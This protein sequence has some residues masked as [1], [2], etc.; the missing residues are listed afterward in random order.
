M[1]RRSSSPSLIAWVGG[2]AASAALGD[3]LGRYHVRKAVRYASV[4]LAL[5]A[6]LAVWRPFAG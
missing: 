6:L 4:L 3:P 1:G 2:R 5:V